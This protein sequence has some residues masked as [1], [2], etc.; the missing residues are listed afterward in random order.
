MPR[1]E[2][3]ANVLVELKGIDF[4]ADKSRL[5]EQAKRNQAAEAS[6]KALDA[7]PEREYTTMADVIKEYGRVH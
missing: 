6:I 1:G 7:L 4:P 2:S 5:I 3:T